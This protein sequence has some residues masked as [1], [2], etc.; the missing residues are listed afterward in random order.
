MQDRKKL[1][2]TVLK[3]TQRVELLDKDVKSTEPTYVK[4]TQGNQENNMCNKQG[5][6][7]KQIIKRK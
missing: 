3:E 7:I 5:I 2:E 4:T 6:S 1:T